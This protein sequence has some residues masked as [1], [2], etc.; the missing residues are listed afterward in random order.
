[1]NQRWRFTRQPL[2][3]PVSNALCRTIPSET[4]MLRQLAAGRSFM[5]VSLA[6]K[7]RW[8]YQNFEETNADAPRNISGVV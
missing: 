2:S 4:S 3:E 8:C 7:R 1:M 5:L 6:L